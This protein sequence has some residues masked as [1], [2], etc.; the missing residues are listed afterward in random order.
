[1]SSVLARPALTTGALA[2]VALFVYTPN[3]S[4]V[5]GALHPDELALAR[6]GC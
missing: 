1:M 3:M 4:S 6:T 5:P 2:V